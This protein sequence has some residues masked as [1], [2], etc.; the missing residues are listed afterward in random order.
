MKIKKLLWTLVIVLT[1]HT[2]HAQ[3]INVFPGIVY[4]NHR[5]GVLYGSNFAAKIRCTRNAPLRLRWLGGSMCIGRTFYGRTANR[6]P[7]SCRVYA[8]ALS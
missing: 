5:V 1:S 8:L 6:K 3:C 4:L 7:F 2:A